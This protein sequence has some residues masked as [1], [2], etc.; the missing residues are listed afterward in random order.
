MS[1]V[2][3]SYRDLDVWQRSMDLIVQV[4][5]LTRGFPREERWGLTSQIQRAVVSVAS[6]IAEGNGRLGRA[7]YRHSLSI[8]RGSLTEVETQ[9]QIAFRLGYIAREE[10]RA[11]WVTLQNTGRLLN[12]LIR[13]LGPNDKRIAEESPVY[14]TPAEAP[15]DDS[16]WE[17]DHWEDESNP[18]ADP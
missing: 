1:K 14:S 7:E 13:S 8:A 17:S 3:K 15:D 16:L 9:L 6:N 2:V 11:T 5:E 10:A 4:Y 12:G 18:F